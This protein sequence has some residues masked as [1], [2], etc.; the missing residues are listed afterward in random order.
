MVTAGLGIDTF[1]HA[2][3]TVADGDGQTKAAR[4]AGVGVGSDPGF[5]ALA[6]HP[7]YARLNQILDQQGF[8]GF[9]GGLCARFYADDGRPGLPRGRSVRLLLIVA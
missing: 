5:A 3:H 8:D 9:V 2:Y 6:A 7:F 1:D 4:E